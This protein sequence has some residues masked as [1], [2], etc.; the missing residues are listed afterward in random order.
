MMVT[1]RIVY[2]R[3]GWIEAGL[4]GACGLCGQPFEVG[5]RII[6]VAAHIVAASNWA[7]TCCAAEAEHLSGHWELR[8]NAP[9]VSC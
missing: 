9:R 1:G 4:P 3:A 8:P 7:G 2:S 5:A 6:R